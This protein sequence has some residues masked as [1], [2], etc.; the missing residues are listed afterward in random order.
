MPTPSGIHTTVISLDA[1]AAE[2]PN[3]VVD[4]D[5]AKRIYESYADL[6]IPAESFA[7]AVA[8]ATNQPNGMDVNEIFFRP[9]RQDL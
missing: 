9:T 1:L 6:A 8:F 2:L 5:A 7:R 3:S 4:L